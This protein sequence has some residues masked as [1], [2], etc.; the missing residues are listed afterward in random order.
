MPVAITDGPLG[1]EALHVWT[2]PQGIISGGIP[3]FTLNDRSL[4]WP[5]DGYAFKLKSIQGLHALPEFIDEREAALGR[6]G[7][8][9]YDAQAGGKNVVYSGDII[10]S[11][12]QYLRRGANVMRQA[13]GAM[14]REGGRVH[15]WA[16]SGEGMMTIT[17]HASYGSENHIFFA[18]T[19]SLEIGDEQLD[20]PSRVPSPYRR[21]FVLTLRLAD[22]RIYHA[23]T[24]S[25]TGNADGAVVFIDNDGSAP[26]DPVFKVQGAFTSTPI[27]LARGTDYVLAFENMNGIA[28]GL[29]VDFKGRRAWLNDDG[30][31]MTAHLSVAD[32]NWWDPG[33]VGLD[34]GPNSVGVTGCGAGGVW[35]VYWL[36]ASY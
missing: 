21:P 7:E 5:L 22:P 24:Q 15:E 26:T 29:W 6:P 10:A 35:E 30:G 3:D 20:G 34:P 32:S 1:L 28:D 31:D 13:F 4:L 12:L 27:V 25:S 16:Q 11:T 33:I 17:P 19:A 8:L 18:R 23:T 36:H 2:P 14:S 9:V